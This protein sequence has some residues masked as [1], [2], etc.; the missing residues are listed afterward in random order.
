MSRHSK[1][2]LL[3]IVTLVIELFVSAGMRLFIYWMIMLLPTAILAAIGYFSYSDAAI[4]LTG[5]ALLIIQLI[6]LAIAY[7]PLVFSVLA[8]AGLGSGH[9]IT[10]FVL[11]AWCEKNEPTRK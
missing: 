8:F 7:G 4:I 11:C 3:Y 9:T 1:T 2:T 6:G 10:R 5:F